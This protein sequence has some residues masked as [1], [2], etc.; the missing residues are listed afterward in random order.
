MP[1]T[2]IPSIKRQ[3]AGLLTVL[4]AGLIFALAIIG[5]LLYTYGP[6]GQY[7]A[8]NILVEPSLMKNLSYIDTEVSRGKEGKHV[9][10]H[11]QFQVFDEKSGQWDV[12]ILNDDQYKRIYD[13]VARDESL[14]P[15]SDDLENKFRSS[16]LANLEIIARPEMPGNSKDQT[17][18]FLSVDFIPGTDAYRVFIR[19][20]SIGTDYAFFIHPDVYQK[21][22]NIVRTPNAW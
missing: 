5:Y 13:L 17:K 22:L 12:Y 3:I 8:Q 14:F 16:R 18:T 11:V 2:E 1:K 15:V 21:V 7:K 6:T 10:D 19:T 4:G 20:S 9:L